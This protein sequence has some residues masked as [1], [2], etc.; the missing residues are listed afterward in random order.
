M[1]HT[2]LRCVVGGTE[3]QLWCPVIARTD[4]GDV[5]LI[6]DENFGGSEIAE[7]QN[8]GI[9]IQEQILGFDVAMADAL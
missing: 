8:T 6:L 4:V 9:G 2:N 7:L 5:G 1:R 3:D